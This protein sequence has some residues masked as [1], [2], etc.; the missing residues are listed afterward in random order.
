M[1]I[2][3]TPE[4]RFNDLKDFPYKPHFVNV[5]GI[6]M[7]YL[8]EGPN[9]STP[10]LLLHGVPTWSYLYRNMIDKTADAGNRVIVPDMIGFGKSD[11]PEKRCDHSYKS[12]IEWIKIFINLLGLKN[13][14]LFGQDWGSLIGLRI[15][16]EQPDRFAGIIISNGM[17]PTGE[18]K[19]HF[20]FKLWKIFARYSPV[21][22][23]D[24]VISAGIKGTLDKE[25]KRAYRAPFP[26]SKY[27]AGIRA[28][29]KHVPVSFNDPEAKANREAWIKLCKWNKP[30]LTAFSNGDPITHGGDK[31]LQDRIPGAAGQNHITLNGGHF[32]QEERAKE[33]SDIIIRFKEKINS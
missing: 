19:M 8:D 31:Y 15:A 16:V 33:L 23:V 20:T 12:H 32:I 7:H 2:L 30:F 22:P 26:S 24:L 6:M 9:N 14:V 27:M 18:Q 13:I 29:P 17:L 1:R 10:V 5:N 25:E 21:L 28:M 11:K 4:Y 3:H